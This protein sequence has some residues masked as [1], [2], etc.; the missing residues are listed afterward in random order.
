MSGTTTRAR[1]QVVVQLPLLDRLMDE[2]PQTAL[3]PAEAL[4]LLRR[5]VRRDVEAL[6]NAR[7]R[8]RSWPRNLKQLAVSPLNFGIPDCTGGNFHDPAQRETLRREIEDTIRRFEPRFRSV[9]VSILESE[10]PLDATLRLRIEALLR[11]EP[12][13][14]PISFDTVVDSVTASVLVRAADYV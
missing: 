7:R 12:A 4:G 1:A 10:N 5:S 3:A 8:W 13:P 6:L 14:E 11:A 9:H 2:T